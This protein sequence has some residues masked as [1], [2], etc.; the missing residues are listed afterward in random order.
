MPWNLTQAPFRQLRYDA[1][2]IDI[3]NSPPAQVS[4][5]YT[6]VAAQ[7][8]APG[9][10]RVESRKLRDEFQNIDT[11]EAIDELVAVP[12][13]KPVEKTT[14]ITQRFRSARQ[15]QPTHIAQMLVVIA[16]NGFAGIVQMGSRHHWDYPLIAKMF[17]KVAHCNG[18]ETDLM[19]QLLFNKALHQAFVDCFS[20]CNTDCSRVVVEL[21]YDPTESFDHT[22]AGSRVDTTCSP[23]R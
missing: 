10:A 9:S 3:N 15:N 16:K 7:V 1:I 11:V 8:V 13:S 23:V 17:P 22:S 20:V 4:Q 18:S 5:E 14:C 12:I 2:Q 6:G 21:T 19:G